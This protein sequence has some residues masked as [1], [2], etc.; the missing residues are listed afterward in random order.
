MVAIRRQSLIGRAINLSIEVVVTNASVRETSKR[1]KRKKLSPARII[2]GSR[3]ERR[4]EGAG[5]PP[6]GAQG[7][8]TLERWQSPLGERA[9]DAV[10]ST[11]VIAIA[12]AIAIAVGRHQR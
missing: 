6:P 12:I 3:L 8:K 2:C 4:F 11:V 9:I 7:P 1:E 10:S 5:V